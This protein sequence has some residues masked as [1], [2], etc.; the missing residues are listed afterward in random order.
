ML[1]V[2]FRQCLLACTL[3]VLAAAGCGDGDD[4]VGGGGTG[5]ASDAHAGATD[6]DTSE[7]TTGPSAG[8]DAAATETQGDGTPGDGAEQAPVSYRYDP[9][10]SQELLTF[11]DDFYMVPDA[12]TGTGLRVDFG[13]ERAPWRPEA[14]EVIQAV[15]TDLEALDGW[16][17][18]AGALLHFDG[19]LADLP[20]GDTAS[21]SSDALMLWELDGDGA[22]TRVPFE[23]KIS[24]TWGVL[25][26]PMRPLRPGARCG[27]IATDALRAADGGRV[28]PSAALRSLLDGS[29]T[30]E[31]L[32][33]LV[34]R[35]QELLSATGVDSTQVVAAVVFT[36]QSATATAVGIA[37]HIRN[38][39]APTWL[40]PPACE[41]VSG[42]RRCVG[43]FEANDY[44]SGSAALVVEPVGSY[45]LPVTFWLPAEADGARPTAL[46]GH[47][48]A[49]DR[50]A[51][52]SM[53]EIA[54]PLGMAV[55]AIDAV[56]H[57]EHP[58]APEDPSFAVLEFFAVQLEPELAFDAYRL[59]DAFRQSTYDKLQAM[60]LVDGHRDVDGDGVD[61][62]DLDRYAYI[63]ESFGG[64][65][66]IE[67]LALTDV[68]DMAALQLGGGRVTS[69]VSDGQRF[70][71]FRLILEPQVGTQADV[72]HFFPLVQ[73]A[74][75]AGDASTFAPHVL[76]ER[77]PGAGTRHPHLML[78]LVIDD[79]T[80]PDVSGYSLAR[81]LGTPHLP[82][83]V[84]SIGVV[85]EVPSAPL[86]ANHTASDRI[87]SAGFFQFDRVRWGD[88]SAPVDKATHD[89]TPA[90]LEGVHQVRRWLETWVTD[91]SPVLV[92]PYAETGTGPVDT[93]ESQR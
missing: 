55:W 42:M 21:L 82:P 86:S 58:T 2:T 18:T 89:Y 57:G 72:E 67:L 64:I 63:G 88:T 7:D 91:G 53:A 52:K 11:P 60:R 4:A 34:P 54:V 90:S 36:V 43:T 70:S 75:D 83:V 46:F 9:L 38:G 62:L 27:V 24:D 74:I 39:P 25:V 1:S 93:E 31:R 41:P 16:G 65:M 76:G 35:Y 61:D 87:I 14:P 15:L 26:R 79:D 85:P 73:T 30:D 71:I 17:T 40:E 32:T 29:A 51:A 12:A 50:G 78:Q 47:G 56:A 68:F 45:V 92:D 13:P 84:E 77:L 81:A 10:G 48:I 5:A 80:I 44:R 3:L 20:S 49:H 8:W 19:A 66:G 28:A 37:D 59:R 69:M 22:A 33:R 6:S 23:V